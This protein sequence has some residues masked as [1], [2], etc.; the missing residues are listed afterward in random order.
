MEYEK[1][2]LAMEIGATQRRG[3]QETRFLRVLTPRPEN[4]DMTWISN[5]LPTPCPIL[6]SAMEF[7]TIGYDAHDLGNDYTRDDRQIEGFCI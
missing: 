5:C 2:A 7:I 3:N 1:L 6:S 4:L